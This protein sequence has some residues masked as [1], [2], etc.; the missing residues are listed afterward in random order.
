MYNI[1]VQP[2]KVGMIRLYMSV[3]SHTPIGSVPTCTLAG[4]ACVMQYAVALVVGLIPHYLN[5]QL[6]TVL[7]QSPL[8]STTVVAIDVDMIQ[9][10]LWLKFYTSKP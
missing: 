9:N 3:L 6:R 5:V 1:H 8:N 7:N 4:T 10:S 2:T